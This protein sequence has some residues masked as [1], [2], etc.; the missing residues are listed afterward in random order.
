[1]ANH[2]NQMGGSH[3]H[4]H[5][6]SH[7][8]NAHAHTSHPETHHKG[9][10]HSGHGADHHA[11]MVADFRRRF[12]VCLVLTVPVVVLSPMIQDWLGFAGS[13]SFPGD[14]YVLLALS[15]VVYFYGGWPFLTG[16]V[17]ELKSK[18]P[19][20]M[21]LVAMAISV[22]FLYSLAIVFGLAGKNVFSGK[23]LR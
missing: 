5:K 18:H 11:H 2:T 20:M 15:A 14:L 1:M 9:A 16:M 4:H 6:T 21:T 22:A 23:P 17:E 12:W 3:D 13:L 8:E 7:P 19:G 10:G